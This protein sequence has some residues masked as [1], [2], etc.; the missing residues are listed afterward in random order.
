MA[1]NRQLSISIAPLFAAPLATAELPDA[2][3]LNAELEAV[4]LAN[5]TEQHRN[6]RPTH[7]PQ[8]EV[9]ESDF[10]LFRWPQ[11]CIQRIRHLVL[12]SIGRVVA[13]LSGY[14][15]QDMARLKMHNHTWFHITRYGGS[16]VAHNHPM[17]SW[18]SVYCV[19]AGEE[20]GERRDSGVLRFLDHRPGSNMFI[21]PANAHLRV[22]FNF[23][24]YSMRLRAGQL[25]IFPSY[26][27]HEVATFMGKDLRITIASNCWFVEQ[28]GSP[29]T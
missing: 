10:D 7:I 19:R 14:T 20:V 12:E 16:F 6:P 3:R 17:A 23:G 28:S 25:V 2:E 22:P 24:H 26:L 4:L 18:S 21:D 27:T 5:E 15:P 1:D 8:R 13:E 11:Q 9:F 29:A